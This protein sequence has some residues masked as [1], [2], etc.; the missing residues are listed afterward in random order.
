MKIT[1]LTEL[2]IKL[3]RWSITLAGLLGL[4]D[5]LGESAEAIVVAASARA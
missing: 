4:D 2:L 3:R 5:T 1:N